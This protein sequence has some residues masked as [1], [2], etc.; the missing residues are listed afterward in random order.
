MADFDPKPYWR[1]CRAD[2]LAIYGGKDVIV[3]PAPNVELLPPLLPRNVGC[4]IAQFAEANHLGFVADTGVSAEY[5]RRTEIHPGY[6]ER[7]KAWL[8]LR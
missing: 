4:D 3:P 7:M 1:Q 6:F 2:V 8:A 5:A